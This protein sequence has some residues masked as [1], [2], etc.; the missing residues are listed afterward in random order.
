M[1]Y[2]SSICSRWLATSGTSL[3]ASMSMNC[4]PTSAI[5]LGEI[6]GGVLLADSGT[7]RPDVSTLVTLH[8]KDVKHGYRVGREYFFVDATTDEERHKTDTYVME[9]L[10]ELADEC[11]QHRDNYSTV[12]YIIGDLLGNLSGQLFPWTRE[13]HCAYEAH[14]MKMMGDVDC[15][16]SQTCQC[17]PQAVS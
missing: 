1:T 11:D 9:V 16:R 13:E 7:L 14:S 8:N 4:T 3:T 17:A 10:C 15:L 12:R 2:T 6:H 5:T